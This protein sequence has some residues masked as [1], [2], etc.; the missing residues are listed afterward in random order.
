MSLIENFKDRVPTQV[1]SNGAIRYEEFDE[2][3]NSLGYKYIKRADEPA[4]VGNIWN[5]V[6]YDGIKEEFYSAYRN[7]PQ[8]LICMWSGSIVPTGWLLCNGENGTPDLRNRFIVGAGHEYDIGDTGGEKEHALTVEEM[9]NHKH[10]IKVQSSDSGYW[11]EEGTHDILG[12]HGHGGSDGL[13]IP[14]RSSSYLATEYDFTIS[15]SETGLGQ[16]SENRPPYYALAF[17]MKA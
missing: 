2:N 8:G 5:K 17:I 7:I 1:L 4:E 15:T 6:L 12:T 13:G 11:T 16:P 10:N 3:G 9:P 14:K